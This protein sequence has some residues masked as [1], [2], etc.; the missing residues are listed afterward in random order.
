MC[1][2]VCCFKQKTAYEI[3]ISDWSSDVCSSDLASLPCHPIHVHFSLR[4]GVGGSQPRAVIAVELHLFNHG[5]HRVLDNF[6]F[7]LRH[8]RNTVIQEPPPKC[9]M[10]NLLAHDGGANLLGAI[11]SASCRDR[12]GQ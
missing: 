1:Y 9:A 6:D 3:R 7:F 8:L 11:G 4:R 2:C 5:N 10:T 12:V